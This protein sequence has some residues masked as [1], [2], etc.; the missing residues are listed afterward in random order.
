[1]YPRYQL[2]IDG[3]REGLNAS[4]GLTK[5]MKVDYRL[6]KQIFIEFLP[7]L[8]LSVAYGAYAVS[9]SRNTATS[10]STF[11]NAFGPSFFLLSWA[12]GQIVRIRKQQKLEDEFQAV[13][14]E[15]A[16]LLGSISEQTRLLIG[17]STGGDSEGYFV[18]TI[19]QPLE[20]QIGF[21]NGSEFPVFD[22]H[23]EWIDLDEKGIDLQNGKFWTR[24][25]LAIGT[26]H[27][28]KIAMRIFTVD[29]SQRD[30][31]RINIFIQTRNSG[32]HQ[33]LRIAKV[34]NVLH[35]ATRT[36]LKNRDE[37]RIPSGFPGYN[38][39]NPDAVFAD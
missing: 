23:A 7:Q 37:T 30:G 31:A 2:L 6:A 39:D 18:P 25:Q 14:K 3:F 16:H 32:G 11:I 17:H 26:I 35:I 12:R 15:L 36:K 21:I 19:S 8:L 9:T 10:L 22:V 1:M 13:K 29:M 33:L 27:P 34:G 20:V 28:N 4:Y 24:N 5:A 38:P